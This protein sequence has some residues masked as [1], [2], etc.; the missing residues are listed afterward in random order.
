VW[1]RARRVVV[2]FWLRPKLLA[3][4][5]PFRCRRGDRL[6]GCLAASRQP[7]VCGSAKHA[8]HLPCPGGVK[9]HCDRRPTSLATHRVPAVSSPQSSGVD[10]MSRR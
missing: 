4:G 8:R 6:I 10:S 1:V 5:Q 9:W 7:R 2:S 3:S